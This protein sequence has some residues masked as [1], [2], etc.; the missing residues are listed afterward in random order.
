MEYVIIGMNDPK[1]FFN[2]YPPKPPTTF[3]PA[4][5]SK[6]IL[7]LQPLEDNLKIVLT[8]LN[9]QPSNVVVSQSYNNIDIALT[10]DTFDG[11]YNMLRLSF[12][13]NKYVPKLFLEGKESMTGVRF[14]FVPVV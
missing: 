9:Y 6:I 14:E 7:E 12:I 2:H 10:I 8:F 13:E 11:L 1:F 3:K 4:Y 5:H